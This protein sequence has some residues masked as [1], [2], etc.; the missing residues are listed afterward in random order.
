MTRWWSCCHSFSDDFR[1]RAESR[2]YE[3]GGSK[4][5]API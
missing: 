4:K 5:V 1:C 3:N 2:N